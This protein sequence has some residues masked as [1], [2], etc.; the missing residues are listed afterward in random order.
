MELD[1]SK[2]D[3]H[4]LML[5]NR[6]KK[7]L[8]H[9]K[10]WARRTGA[11]V[12]RLYDRDIPEIPL[13]LDYY[14]DAALPQES[15]LAGALYKRPYEKNEGEEDHWLSAMKD[16]VA[17]ALNITSDRIFL[18]QRSRQRGASQYEKMD[19]ARFTK[20]V[21]ENGLSFKVN[22]SDYLDCGL[23]PD[24]RLLRAFVRDGA[25]GKR[26]LNL[27]SYTGS[28]SVYAVAGGA[29]STDSVDLSN[30]YLAWARENFLLNGFATGL[31]G[32]P[33]SAHSL[34]REDALVY[35]DKASALG[36]KWDVIVLDPPAFS[37]SKKMTGSFDL[38]R[39]IIKTV[40][41]CLGLLA[42][43][44]ELILSANAKRFKTT[45]QEL[46]EALPGAS[47][48]DLGNKVTDEDFRGRKKQ[49]S[50]L[51]KVPR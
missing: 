29:V 19:Q 15:A 31:K 22:L 28:F 38:C 30:T 50:F 34:I 40:R 36:K 6:L 18:K 7:R 48:A 39:D 1:I 43:G 16:T 12:F 47:A 11:G 20:V 21:K 24:R 49:A 27:F 2:T 51:I 45:A 4:A 35:I 32:N 26:V 23:F 14:G 33:R 13:V 42:P 25:A 17:Q 37:N 9:L 3:F 44:G 10:K 41:S 5:S 8:R 46:E